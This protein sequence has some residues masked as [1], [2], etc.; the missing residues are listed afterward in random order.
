M[1]GSFSSSV[2]LVAASS[3]LFFPI[4][5]GAQISQIG[6]TTEPQ[7]VSPGD[8]SGTLTFQLQDASGSPF[9]ATETFD[10]EF[11]SSS[12][13]GEF[14]S[15]AS[16][17]PVTKTLSTG[18]ANK[19]FRYR[20]STPGT[21]TLTIHATGR[22]SGLLV[23]GTQNIV[24]GASTGAASFDA[25]QNTSSLSSSSG[26]NVN[27]RAANSKKPEAAILGK[28]RI[29]SVGSPLEFK[30]ETNL[31]Y[32]KRAEF[33]WNFGDGSEEYGEELYH[34]YEYPG[35]YVV[36]LNVVTPGGKAAA[37]ANV[38]IT[39]PQLE[40]IFA[41]PQRIEIKNSSKQEVNL[42]G[43]ALWVHNQSFL[44]P[45][46]TFIKPNQ[47]ISFA[48]KVTGLRPNNVYEAQL[49]TV[50]QTEQPKMGEK[51]EALK[52]EKIAELQHKIWA[53][54]EE[55][56]SR[57]APRV[58]VISPVVSTTTLPESFS[59]TAAAVESLPRQE[60]QFKT[61]WFATLKKFLLGN[62]DQ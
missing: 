1:R 12:A 62:N 11:L 10:V 49:L 52:E 6:F 3:L 37:R 7:T 24:V 14:L 54:Q 25:S 51:I 21:H 18:S 56:A 27:T 32:T 28:D 47:T 41:N 59:A 33:R 20:D 42:H 9:Q 26:A 61:G 23:S 36:V 44:F 16:E 55:V 50:G 30:A 15:P 58:T 4:W 53:L 48:A 34:T 17:N 46:D 43:S 39:A 29:G 35:E 5:A 38:K 57:A 22:T 19:N 13:S 60:G 45:Q 31:S 8:L 2:G 40:I